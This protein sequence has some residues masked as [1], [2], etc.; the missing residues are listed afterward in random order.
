MKF[1]ELTHLQAAMCSQ[2]TDL[3]IEEIEIIKYKIN[4]FWGS[5]KIVSR[6]SDDTQLFFTQK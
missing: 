4:V 6:K 3:S 5:N 1:H 2:I